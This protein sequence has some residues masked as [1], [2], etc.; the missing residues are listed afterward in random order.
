MPTYRGNAT[1][2]PK[3][4]RH[5]I[6]LWLVGVVEIDDRTKNIHFIGYMADVSRY[7]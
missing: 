1:M 3:I 5:F 2:M 4:Q 6:C 7:T